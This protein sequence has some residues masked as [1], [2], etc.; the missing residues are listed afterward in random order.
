MHDGGML[1]FETF[2]IVNF[3]L[4]LSD[5]VWRSFEMICSKCVII[6]DF[7]CSS[8]FT[9]STFC[10]KMIFSLRKVSSCFFRLYWSKVT[11]GA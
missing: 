11:C 8:S 7:F 5:L 6:F 9:F 4:D 3:G 2:E 10:S 1:W